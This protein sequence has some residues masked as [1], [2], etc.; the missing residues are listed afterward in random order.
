[1]QKYLPSMVIEKKTLSM[2]SQQGQIIKGVVKFHRLFWS[3][4]PH[5]DGFQY[6]KLVV[7]VDGTWLYRKYKGTFLVAIT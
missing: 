4:K 6:C 7:Q 2:P 5:I 3:F 1:M